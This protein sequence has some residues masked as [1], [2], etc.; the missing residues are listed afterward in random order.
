MAADDHLHDELLRL[1]PENRVVL[2]GACERMAAARELSTQMEIVRAMEA[3]I[4][5]GRHK[6]E[7]R[8]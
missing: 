6:I 4:I 5:A 8:G 1:M 7:R 3:R 2:A